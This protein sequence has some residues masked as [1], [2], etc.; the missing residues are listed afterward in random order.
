MF[1]FTRVKAERP[2]DSGVDK[3][4]ESK[5]FIELDFSKLWG[6]VHDRPALV[7]LLRTRCWVQLAKDE[8]QNVC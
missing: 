2:V 8:I 1:A 3:Q 4:K 6:Y 5:A 7:A